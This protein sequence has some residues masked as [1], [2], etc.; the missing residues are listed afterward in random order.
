MEASIDTGKF[1]GKTINELLQLYQS[2]VEFYNG[3]N[4]DKYQFYT[5]K[6]QDL[7]IRPEVLMAM[8]L[9]SKAQKTQTSSSGSK[10]RSGLPRAPPKTP[11]AGSPS[12]TVNF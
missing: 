3:Q 7:I 6:I 8:N 2:A 11:A 12:K 5:T 4:N 9:D 1:T 10:I